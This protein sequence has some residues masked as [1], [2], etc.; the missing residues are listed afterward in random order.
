MNSDN[1]EDE[2]GKKNATTARVRESKVRNAI[3]L[4]T[5][6]SGDRV[7]AKLRVLAVGFERVAR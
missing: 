6:S 3:Q 5:D 2:I 1:G 4:H 7:F